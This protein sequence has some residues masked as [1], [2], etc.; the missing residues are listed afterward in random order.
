M[1]LFS[2]LLMA[3]S[4]V[5]VV[6]KYERM[7]GFWFELASVVFQKS[8]LPLFFLFGWFFNFGGRFASAS[9]KIRLSRNGRPFKHVKRDVFFEDNP[10]IIIVETIILL[11]VSYQ[12]QFE[13]CLFL[14]LS[15]IRFVVVPGHDFESFLCYLL[16]IFHVKV[17]AFLMVLNHSEQQQQQQPNITITHSSK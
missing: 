5:H 8:F 11:A 14:S 16:N 9:H 4:C 1:F 6:P 13:W 3:V 12:I 2:L 10:I 15:R 7:L 17:F